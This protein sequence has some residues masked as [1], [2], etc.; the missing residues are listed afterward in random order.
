MNKTDYI[1]LYKE[2][3]K[4][5]NLYKGS[6]LNL[7][8]PRIKQ[9]IQ[10]TRS[11]TL[12]D[13]GCGKGIQYTKENFHNDFFYG[14]MPALY[15]PAVPGF[16]KL[17]AGKFDGVF[18]TDVFEHI[19]EPVLPKVLKEIYTRATKFVYLGICNVPATSFLPNGENAHITLK[20]FDE[21]VDLI[22]PCTKGIFTM[23][24]VYGKK[25][26]TAIIEN[27]VITMKHLKG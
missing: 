7:H 12:L 10:Q 9:M 6:S 24:Y 13:Y 5:E 19:P 20:S 17:P 15:D 1:K 4:D 14:I 23:V 26:G 18:S 25:K 22:A 16:S 3:H 2:M 27:G 21:W 8:A 11:K